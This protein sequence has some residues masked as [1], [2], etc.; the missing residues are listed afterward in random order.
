MAGRKST[1]EQVTPSKMEAIINFMKEHNCGFI[2]R[3]NGIEIG[4]DTRTFMAE[5][6][7]R[8]MQKNCNTYKKK[9]YIR[10]GGI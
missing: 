8:R 2:I 4:I 5:L 10:K 9:L 1:V 7:A 3:W 6:D